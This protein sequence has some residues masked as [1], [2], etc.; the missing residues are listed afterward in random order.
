MGG[1][2]TE[3]PVRDGNNWYAYCNNNPVR[4]VDPSGKIA[5]E[6]ANELYYELAALGTAA[7]WLASPAGQ[8]V[9]NNLAKGIHDAVETVVDGIQAGIEAIGNF[10]GDAIDSIF[11]SSDASGS[12]SPQKPN[13][14]SDAVKKI[15]KKLRRV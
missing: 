1:F 14:D 5:A 2:L 3:D 6:I 11:N 7:A 9:I 8:N 15:A 12:P 4:Y 10:I 13:D